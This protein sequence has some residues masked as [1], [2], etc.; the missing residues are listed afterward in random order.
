MKLSLMWPPWR[1]NARL[2]GAPGQ[3][4]VDRLR[5]HADVADGLRAPATP[6]PVGRAGLVAPDA[7]AFIDRDE[8]IAGAVAAQREP[9]VQ[10]VRRARRE[11][12]QALLV[13]LA[14]ADAQ[15]RRVPGVVGARERGQLG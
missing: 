2:R 1:G 13:A 8:E 6:P 4:A 14:G 12:D 9:G 10:R 3:H 15:R 5:A 11:R 7:A